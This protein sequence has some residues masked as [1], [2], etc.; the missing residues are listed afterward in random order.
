MNDIKLR[1]NERFNNFKHDSLF[2]LFY[3]TFRNKLKNKIIL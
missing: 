2:E 1:Q 3:K